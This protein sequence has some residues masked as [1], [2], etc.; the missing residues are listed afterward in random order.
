MDGTPGAA[1]VDELAPAAGRRRGHPPASRRLPGQRR[2][3][4]LLRGSGI[5]TVVFVGVA[6]NLSVEGT[7]RVASDLGYRTVVVADACSAAPPAA[8]A[9]SLESLGLLAEIVTADELLGRLGAQATA[10]TP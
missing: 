9:A 4:R 8:H 3:T 5:D 6:T 2:S 7:A 10:V 1:I